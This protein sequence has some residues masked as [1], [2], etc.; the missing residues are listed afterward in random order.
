MRELILLR[1]AHAESAAVGQD[2][3]R[4]H[5]EPTLVAQH[6]GILRDAARLRDRP[7][8]ELSAQTVVEVDE[9]IPREHFEAAAKVIGFVMQG[10]KRR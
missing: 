9:I 1:H 6:L 8:A 7:R 2:D 3:R 5:A 10:R 4:G